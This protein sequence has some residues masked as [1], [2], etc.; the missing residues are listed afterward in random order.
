M[1]TVKRA[2]R[3]IH[4]H[5]GLRVPRA[6]FYRWLSNGT[7][8]TTRLH[9]SIRIHPAALAKFL[10]LHTETARPDFQDLPPHERE[11][12]QEHNRALLLIL[13][14][15]ITDPQFPPGEP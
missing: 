10:T 1:L 3:L 14:A 4:L 5:T 8:L 11:A 7:I 12:A 13:N 6:T 9:H 15:Q 2:R